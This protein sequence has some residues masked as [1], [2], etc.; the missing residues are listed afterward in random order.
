[1]LESQIALL[2]QGKVTHDGL[3]AVGT[4]VNVV[5]ATVDAT[6]IE[7]RRDNNALL[8][9]LASHM[10]IGNNTPVNTA[11]RLRPITA[12]QNAITTGSQEPKHVGAAP[13]AFVKGSSETNI[14]EG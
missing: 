13:P 12:A 1:M 14:H 2:K 8:Y 3:E 10:A 9:G 6:R 7:L 5:K 11:T 4:A